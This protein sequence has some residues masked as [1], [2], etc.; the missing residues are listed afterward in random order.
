[1]TKKEA[2]WLARPGQTYKNHSKNVAE[3]CEKFAAQLGLE[4]VLIDLAYLMGRL[5]DTGKCS[6]EF[7]RKLAGAN[8]RV[9]HSTAGAQIV[10]KLGGWGRIISYCIAGHHGGLP[11]Y[12]RDPKATKV[13]S[14]SLEERLVKEI[15]KFEVPVFKAN[16]AVWLDA[17]QKSPVTNFIANSVKCENTN[18][19]IMLLARMLYSCLVDADRLDAE[20]C[21]D[22]SKSNLRVQR[23]EL[24]GLSGHLDKHLAQFKPD[25]FVNRK[26]AR[27]LSACQRAASLEPGFFSLT[28]PTGGAKTLSS[29]SFGLRHAVKYGKKRIIYIIPYTSI[30]EQTVDTFR[31]ILGVD[32]RIVLEHHSNIGDDDSFERRLV[33]ENW[34]ALITVSTNVQFYESLFSHQSSKCRKLHNI[35]NSVIILDEAQVIRIKTMEPCLAVLRDLVEFYG[36]SV[37]LCTAT[38]PAIHKRDDFKIGIAGVREIVDDPVGLY[39]AMRR[40]DLRNLGYLS[41][42][43]LLSRIAAEKQV[44]CVVN[45]RRDAHDIFNGLADENAFHL[46]TLMCGTHR[47]AVI[48]GIK[49]RLLN[50]EPCVVISTQ[51]IEAGVDIDFP[52]VFRALAGI[53]EIV[54]AAGRCNREGKLPSNGITYL[55][56]YGISSHIQSSAKDTTRSILRRFTDI[57]DLN[58]IEQYFHEHMW[59]HEGEMDGYGA[60]KLDSNTEFQFATIGSEFRL[61]EDDS[62]SVVVPYGDGLARLARLVEAVVKDRKHEQ[63]AL[64]RGLQRFMVS[65]KRGEYED[66]LGEGI[67]ELEAG[68]LPVVRDSAH[69]LGGLGLLLWR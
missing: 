26:R 39:N 68:E 8:I 45:T 51:L 40:V 57:L 23:S 20:R 61:I 5:H 50:G 58:V 47:S 19:R 15:P 49:R 53:D 12:H 18:F 52:V 60:M 46:S 34:D 38:Q 22:P 54:Q 27:I 41:Q 25:S 2:T 10:N 21:S 11:N 64:L 30:I 36:C 67:V 29:L 69:Y 59:R 44:L 16:L 35:A 62:V 66:L 37:V 7:L 56:D 43:Q 13:K 3:R 9:D 17:D 33:S 6:G 24:S 14:S 42:D 55:F 28:A 1:M 63:H 31:S 4:Q 48:A 32:P 65:V